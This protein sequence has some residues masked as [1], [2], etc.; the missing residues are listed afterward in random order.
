MSWM[1]PTQMSFHMHF[2]CFLGY[3][4]H[5]LIE[6]LTFWKICALY[7]NHKVQSQVP[8]QDTRNLYINE[9][10]YCTWLMVHNKT[11]FISPCYQ[12]TCSLSHTIW[13]WP[14]QYLQGKKLWSIQSSMLWSMRLECPISDKRWRILLAVW[15]SL[16]G[17][18]SEWGWWEWW[19][20]C[21]WWWCFSDSGMPGWSLDSAADS[22]RSEWTGPT[23]A[24]TSLSASDSELV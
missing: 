3:R 22:L 21:G 2:S 14:L 1:T 13:T 20:W 15:L 11:K 16:A 17:C 9:R 19:W 12:K 8:C 6:I 4:L 24:S 7:H 18:S 10:P 5:I 23:T